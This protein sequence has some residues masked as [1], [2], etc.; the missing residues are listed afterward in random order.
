MRAAQNG[1]LYSQLLNQ[2]SITVGIKP[3]TF[4]GKIFIKNFNT[5]RIGIL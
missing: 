4:K 1:I 3:L 5:V 2:G